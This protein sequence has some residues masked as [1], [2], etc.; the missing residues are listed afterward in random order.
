MP[1]QLSRTE[2]PKKTVMTGTNQNVTTEGIAT[3]MEAVTVI[4][5][6]RDGIE[7]V[8]NLEES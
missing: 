1:L 5:T 8:T 3:A 2:L 6:E 4:E 7:V